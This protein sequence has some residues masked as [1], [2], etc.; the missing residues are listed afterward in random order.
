M[1]TFNTDSRALAN[2]LIGPLAQSA[3]L[4][5]TTFRIFTISRVARILKSDVFV[6]CASYGL[7]QANFIE[8]CHKTYFKNRCGSLSAYLNEEKA[9]NRCRLA[10]KLPHELCFAEA[11]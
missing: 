2:R 3:S 6:L 1:P 7:H 5:A 10:R 11:E 4:R 9:A 8:G